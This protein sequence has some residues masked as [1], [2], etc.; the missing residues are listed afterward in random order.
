[1]ASLKRWLCS[2]PPQYKQLTAGSLSSA[3]CPPFFMQL[4]G[5]NNGGI[6][7]PA[8]L[9]ARKSNWLPRSCILRMRNVTCVG[10]QT[11]K[12]PIRVTLLFIN[13]SMLPPPNRCAVRATYWFH[14]N[15]KEGALHPWT[16]TTQFVKCYYSFVYKCIRANTFL[17]QLK[18]KIILYPEPSN[19]E[20]LPFFVQGFWAKDRGET[21]ALTGEVMYIHI[22][23][24]CRANFFQNQP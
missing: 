12:A 18:R 2:L 10:T 15:W 4:T 7:C 11:S 14:W 22:F 19:L 23:V 6:A 1:M 5:Q 9:L 21:R 8:L 17:S 24:F 3:T 16:K 13:Y 20:N